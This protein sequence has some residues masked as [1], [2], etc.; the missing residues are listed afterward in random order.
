M[1]LNGRVNRELPIKKRM[2]KVTLGSKI[3]Q[4]WKFSII[5]VVAD[6]RRHKRDSVSAGQIVESSMMLF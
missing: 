4:N 3:V 1:K 5:T 2:S 6:I